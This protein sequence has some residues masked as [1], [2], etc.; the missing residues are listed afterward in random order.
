M[1]LGGLQHLR[2]IGHEL[3]IHLK[4]TGKPAIGEIDHHGLKRQ[5]TGLF[6][7]LLGGLLFS[8]MLATAILATQ[9]PQGQADTETDQQNADNGHDDDHLLVA[10]RR[11]YVQIQIFIFGVFF[12]HAV[13]P[14][15][16]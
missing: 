5:V 10:G 3:D 2:V 15:S 14:V 4:V 6:H 7:A 8:R 13:Y 1:L 9:Q 12:S 11:F 16:G